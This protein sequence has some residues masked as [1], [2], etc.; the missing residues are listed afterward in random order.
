M[1]RGEWEIDP[2][3]RFGE[4]LLGAAYFASFPLTP[5]FP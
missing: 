1:D 2:R 4:E 5:P 3:T